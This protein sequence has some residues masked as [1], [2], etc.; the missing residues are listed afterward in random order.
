MTWE[1]HAVTVRML[2]NAKMLLPIKSCQIKQYR[3]LVFKTVYIF[4]NE[5]FE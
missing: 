2:V 4:S 5:Q 1:G 3:A